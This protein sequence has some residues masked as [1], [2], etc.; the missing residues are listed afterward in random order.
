M[1]SPKNIQ[2]QFTERKA[3]FKSVTDKFSK[4]NQKETDAIFQEKHTLLLTEEQ[5]LE[6]ANCCKSLGPR[7]TDND[8]QRMSKFLKIKPGD[9][10]KQYL[11]ID[12]DRDYVFNEM[13]C[14]F[15]ASDNYCIIYNARPKACREYPHTDRKKIHQI[16]KETFLNAATCPVVY[17]ILKEISTKKK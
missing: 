12:E 1:I 9:F 2:T 13:P 3:V 15:L 14:P 7:I 11:R 5:C 4:K 8:I 6:C 10:T 16:K 17:E